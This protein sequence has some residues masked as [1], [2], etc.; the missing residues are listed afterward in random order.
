MAPILL[1]AHTRARLQARTTRDLSVA[2]AS[3]RH[4]RAHLKARQGACTRNSAAQKEKNERQR[5]KFCSCNIG[6]IT[7]E[8]NAA[9]SSP[10]LLSA[11]TRA[12]SQTHATRRDRQVST[13][14]PHPLASWRSNPNEPR[15]LRFR[16]CEKWLSMRHSAAASLSSNPLAACGGPTCTQRQTH[17]PRTEM[18]SA[19]Q[20]YTRV[21]LRFRDVT[22]SSRGASA[23]SSSIA[24]PYVHTSSRA[25]T[26]QS[27]HVSASNA[28]DSQKCTQTI[29]EHDKSSSVESV[30]PPSAS[31]FACSAEK[32]FRVAAMAEMTCFFTSQRHSRSASRVS[33]SVVMPRDSARRRDLSA[34]APARLRRR[35]LGA[36]APESQEKKQTR[37]T[38]TPL[39]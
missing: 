37:D 6:P 29:H 15:R 16:R 30:P 11:N 8:S 24:P 17:E 36:C 33:L 3:S 25:A 1:T 22:C 31:T 26:L 28:G 23:A 10:I 13:S 5:S 2:L 20:T 32:L 4:A 34:A 35:Q 9:P 18:R 7:P 39:P 19:H 21:Q 38:F 12:R 27:K 14:L